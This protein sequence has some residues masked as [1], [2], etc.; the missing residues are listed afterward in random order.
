MII[1]AFA[2]LI[3]AFLLYLL[4]TCVF[5]S[6]KLAGVVP[7]LMI[8]LVVAV[9]FMR[10]SNKGMLAGFVSGLLMDLTYGQVVGLFAL[11]YMFI[12]FISGFAHK[13]YDEMDYTTPIFLVGI[14]ELMY[15]LFYYFFFYFL[16][17]RL[18]IGYYM[19]R[20]M[21]PRMIY[22]VLVSLLL[23]RLFNM[24]NILF[25]RLDEG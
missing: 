6:F 18:N 15:N 17:G 20:F 8:I 24:E 7:D 2:V 4:Q 22:T 19:F 25:G 11:M 1:R 9:A 23:Y 12:G 14:S 3:Q 21:I 5:T 10:G 13:I 16:Q